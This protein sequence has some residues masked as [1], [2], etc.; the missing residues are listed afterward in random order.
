MA[1]K[2]TKSLMPIDTGEWLSPRVNKLS[3]VVRGAWITMLCYMWESPT[4]GVMAHADGTSYT[5]KEILTFLGINAGVLDKLVECGLLAVNDD[6]AYFSRDMMRKERL[7]EIRRNAGRIG[8]AAAKQKADNAISENT[9]ATAP[10]II[11]PPPEKQALTQSNSLFGD[12]D[13]KQP[14]PPELTPAQKAK[15][16]KKKKIRYAEY[17]EMTAEEY[18]KLCER[19]GEDATKG[20]IDILDNYI[21]S[22]GC[23]TKYKNHYRA[24]LSWVVDAYNEKKLRNGNRPPTNPANATRGVGYASATTT[25]AIPTATG[26]GSQ[27]GDAPEKDYSERF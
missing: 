16:N 21:G 3:Y 1:K 5:R 18:A 12:E 2:R 15:A 17:V 24:I 27:S 4:K 10:V 23:F 13:L 19:F 22:K 25:G 9:T 20:M 14:A 26:A 7:S 6:G 11:E 8:G